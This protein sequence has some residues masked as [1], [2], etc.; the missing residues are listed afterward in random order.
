MP[1]LGVLG[2]DGLLLEDNIES[3]VRVVLGTAV[4]LHAVPHE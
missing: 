4:V 2:E 3:K 1:H